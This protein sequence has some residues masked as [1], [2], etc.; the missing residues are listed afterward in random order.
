MADSFL[1]REVSTG[2]NQKTWTVS[3]WI[4]MSRT[5]V[6]HTIF[7]SDVQDDGSNYATLSIDGPGIIK[8]INYQGGSLVTNFQSNRKLLDLYHSRNCW[9]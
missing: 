7:G 9:R 4:K 2:T 6:N 1:K 8:F 3:A 5:G